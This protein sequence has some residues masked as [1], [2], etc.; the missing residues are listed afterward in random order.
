[1]ASRKYTVRDSQGL[2]WTGVAR[3][4]QEAQENAIGHWECIGV[5][6]AEIVSI[7]RV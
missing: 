4:T 2:E 1:M 7:R 3:D 5:V 6:Y